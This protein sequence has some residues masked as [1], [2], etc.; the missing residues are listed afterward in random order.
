MLLLLH[1]SILDMNWSP[2]SEDDI[3]QREASIMALGMVCT[4]T[5]DAAPFHSD[6]KFCTMV[7][8]C[9]YYSIRAARER[10][11]QQYKRSDKLCSDIETLLRAEDAYRKTWTF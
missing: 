9:S 1:G 4:M 5:L 2:E 10:L 6:D 8:I 7:P 11:Q 3:R